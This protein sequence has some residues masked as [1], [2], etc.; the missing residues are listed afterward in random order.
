MKQFGFLGLGIMGTAMARNLLHAGYPVTVWNRTPGKSGE[1]EELGATVA[2]SPAAVMASCQITF[3][4]LADPTA[5]RAVCFGTDGVLAGTS[6]GKGYVDFSTV[7]AATSQEI[8]AALAAKGGQFLEAPVSGSKKPAEDGT[9]IIL[10]AGDR[11]L[12]D[13]ALPCLEKLGKKCLH[14]GAVGNGAR[15]KIVVNMI[16]GG[17]MAAFSE[18]LALGEKAELNLTDILEVLDAGA[19]AN[20][21]F[22]GKGAGILAGSY[23]TAF[24]LKHMQ[25]DLRLALDLG[26][27]LAQPLSCTAAANELF[28]GARQAGLGEEDFSALFKK[29]R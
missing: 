4:M 14:L 1:L 20:P 21:L 29:V 10:T 25:K 5:A 12:Y 2:A 22:R 27:R 28:K 18:G 17:M 23:S 9:L 8:H 15:M 19:L 7:D 11:D 16:M 6:P 3:A 24:P 26:D 13:E